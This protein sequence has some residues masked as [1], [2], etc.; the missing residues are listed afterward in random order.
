[1][2][3]GAESGWDFSTR[4][5]IAEDGSN[6]GE[7]DDVKITN[8]IPVDLNSFIC[9]NAKLL[10]NMFSLLGDEEKSQFYLDKFIKW[11]EA[12]QMVCFNQ[13]DKTYAISP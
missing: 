4:W 6:V 10:S 2:K 11:K 12:I 7:L 5:F 8:I 3:S 9:M 1:M 13:N